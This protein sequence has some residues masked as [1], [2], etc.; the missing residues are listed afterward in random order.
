MPG[1]E[2]FGVRRIVPLLA[3]MLGVVFVAGPCLAPTSE[4]ST[5]QSPL[6]AA[7]TLSV[8]LSY[9]PSTVSANAQT[10]GMYSISGGTPP[11][12]IW[13]NNTPPG[14]NPQSNPFM[15]SSSSDQFACTPTSA[16][17][18]SVHVDVVDSAGTRGSASATLTVN[19]SGNGGNGNGNG[20]GS[21]G[22]SLPTDLITM[23]T[24]FGALF[25]GAIVA[26]AAG[27][28]VMTVLM[29]RRLRQLNETLAKANQPSTEEKPPP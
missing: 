9:S 13:V 26:L 7:A 1:L 23:L 5:L 20:T 6:R 3:L 24:L 10:Q 8:S 21:G 11:F 16:G 28:I 22:F 4:S 15:T 14:C 2:S 19:T 25:V 18:Y 27:V 12:T 17:T 29:S